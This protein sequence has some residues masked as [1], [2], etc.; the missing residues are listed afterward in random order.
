MKFSEIKYYAL[1]V[2][3]WCMPFVVVCHPATGA[4]LPVLFLLAAMP[5]YTKRIGLWP[6]L[7]ISLGGTIAMFVVA[8]LIG[9]EIH[10]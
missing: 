6:M 9:C 10:P 2:P 7:A 4:I 8:A 5:Y 1:L 3:L